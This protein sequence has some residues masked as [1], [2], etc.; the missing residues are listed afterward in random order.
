M[1]NKVALVIV[2]LLALSILLPL[3][4]AQPQGPWVDEVDFFAEKDP[5]KVIDMLSKGDMQIYFTEIRA[6]PALMQ[7]IKSDP[8]L[9]YTYSYGLYYDLTFN[10]VGPEFPAT[11]K[12]NPFSDPRIREAMNWLVDRNYIAN[13]IFGGL[14][15]PKWLPIVNV[16][17]DYARIA[18]TAKALEAKYSYD[19]EKAKAVIFEEMSKLG[20][21]FKDG[22]WYYKGSPVEI[23][24][25]IRTEDHRKQIGDYVADQLQK[26]GFTVIR[27]YGT[28]RDLAPLWIRGNPADGKWNIYTGGWI[29]TAVER[30][31]ASNFGFFYTP[32]ASYMGPLWQAYKP[33]P[34]FYEVATKLWNGQFT[35]MEE[36]TQ[37]IAKAAELALKDSVRIW[38]VDQIAPRVYRKEV[39]CASDFSAGFDN[40]LWPM[41]LRYVGKEGGTIKAGMREVLVDPWNPVAGT[42]WV[43]DSVLL[44]AVDDYA[45]RTNPYTGLQM[46]NRLVSAEVYA[47]KGIVTQSSSDW[48]KLTFVDKVEVPADAWYAYDV[49]TGKVITSGEAGVKYAQVKIVANYGDVLG[50]IK[51]HDGTTMTLADWLIGWPLTF[52]RVDPSSPLYDKSAIASFQQWRD[53][54]RGWRIVSTS[55]LVIEYYVNY[56]ALDAE[57]IVFGFAGWPSNPWHMLAIGIRAEEKGLLAFSADKAGEMNVEWM[58]YIGGPSLD[59]LSKMLSEAQ[60]EGYIPFKAFMSNY[61][62]PDEVNAR[63]TALKNWYQAHGHFYVGAGPFYLDKVDYNAHIAVLKANR[64]FPDKADRWSFLAT[65]PIPEVSVKVPDIVVPGAEATFT[66]NINVGGKPYPTGRIDFVKYM[67]LDAQGNVYAKGVAT[68]QADGVWIVKL[69]GEDTGKLTPGSYRILTITLSKDVATPVLVEKPFTVTSQIAYFQTLLTQVQ[70]SLESKLGSLQ[71]GITDV[72]NKVNNLSS[73]VSGIESTLNMALALSVVSLL[74]AIV[75]LAMGLRKPKTVEKTSQEATQVKS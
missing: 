71:A 61:V 22:K 73:R 64:N 29:T 20:A 18:D 7:K 17:P 31:S 9:K 36:R 38:L 54:M 27:R 15:V 47:L 35:S 21:T 45:Y 69:S 28:S 8:N 62:K 50:K 56:T 26:L 60:S 5:A 74:L 4:R 16:F 57:A 10:P 34:I 40:N 75:A 52:A 58:N 46:A 1:K 19:F 42:N 49:K 43:Y 72:N 55:P 2:L 37:L 24:I 41:T 32:L 23:T 68:P 63:Y 13:E 48:L 3:L 65:P 51:Y 66:L 25:L 70:S 14:A 11:G 6:D 53:M 44:M 33:D 59:I 39:Q 67:V 30:D 12:L